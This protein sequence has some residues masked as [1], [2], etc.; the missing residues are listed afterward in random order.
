[1]RELEVSLTSLNRFGETIAPN[2][3]QIILVPFGIPGER[4][5]VKI[6]RERRDLIIGELLDVIEP[7]P[8]RQKPICPLFG[9]CSGCNFQ[10]IKYEKQVEV[11][12]KILI[13]QLKRI[14]GLEEPETYLAPFRKAEETFYYRN[15][16]DF[17]RNRE[18]LLGSRRKEDKRFI[19]IFHCY[20]MHKRINEILTQIQGLPPKRKSHNVLVRY[21]VNTGS[22]LVQPP[23]ATDKIP[24]GQEVFFEKVLGEGFQISASSFFQVNTKKTE[25]IVKIILGYIDEADRV[26]IDAYAGVGTFSLFLGKRGERVIAIE[27]SYTAYQDALENLKEEKN[28]QFLL[29]KTEKI[30]PEVKG[31]ID[32]I[33]LD[34]PR[35]GCREEVLKTVAE[36]EIKKLIYVSCDPTSLAWNL[37]ILMNQGYRL[38]EIHPIDMFPQTYHLETITLMKKD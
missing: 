26:V 18:N 23:M 11:K 16:A 22:F 5:R 33:I 37:K 27:E 28:V 2:N 1:M 14:T 29:G 30:L 25:E 35:I 38:I 3:G 15:R 31:E 8:F 6:I 12:T 13:E 4:V 17:S 10:H 19:P 34:P 20:L 32:A 21:G 24:T 7:S 9:V 36:K